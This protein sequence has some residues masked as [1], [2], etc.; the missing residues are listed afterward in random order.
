VGDEASSQKQ[1][2][3]RLKL[4]LLEQAQAEEE[5]LSKIESNKPDKNEYR[6]SHIKQNDCRY[7]NFRF[8][9]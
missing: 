7:S 3:Q 2:Q 6:P 4:L 8:V 5:L 1:K 9:F